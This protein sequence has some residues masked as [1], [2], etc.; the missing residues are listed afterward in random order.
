LSISSNVIFQPPVNGQS[1]IK[2]SIILI[3][4]FWPINS[5]MED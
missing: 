1:S 5:L 4:H 3:A 2:S